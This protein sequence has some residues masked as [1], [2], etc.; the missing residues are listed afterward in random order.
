[1]TETG[2]EKVGGFGVGGDVKVQTS[3]VGKFSRRYGT[4][5]CEFK[6]TRFLHGGEGYAMVVRERRINKGKSRCSTINQCIS[7]D[8]DCSYGAVS[9]VKNDTKNLA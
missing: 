4:T 5:V 7:L 6:N 1:M 9:Y 3:K 8:S 2:N